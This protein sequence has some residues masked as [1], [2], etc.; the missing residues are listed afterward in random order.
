MKQNRIF[1]IIALVLT[2]CFF[3]G[4]KKNN[5]E[6]CEHNFSDA[7][8]TSPSTCTKCGETRGT[9]L[10][11]DWLDATYE[12]PKTCQ[13]CGVTEGDPVGEHT[14]VFKKATCTKPKICR[15]CS[16]KKEVL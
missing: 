6:A 11:H 15:I 9:A 5:I 7:T 12:S 14:H 1:L 3:S 2:I 10:G 8:C 16:L 4:C 13:R